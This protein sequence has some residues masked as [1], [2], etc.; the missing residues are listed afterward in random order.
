M[1]IAQTIDRHSRLPAHVR[2]LEIYI[3]ARVRV[4]LCCVRDE[5][6]FRLKIKVLIEHIM[7]NV[8]V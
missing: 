1:R 3:R 5:K 7:L 4:C 2:L 6:E 8:F